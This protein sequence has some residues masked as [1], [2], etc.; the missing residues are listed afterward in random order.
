MALPIS[1]RRAVAE[2]VHQP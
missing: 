2:V 1:T